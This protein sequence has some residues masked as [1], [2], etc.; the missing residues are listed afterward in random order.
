ME[1]R[2]SCKVV[3]DEGLHVTR[4][5]GL[6]GLDDSLCHVE[7]VLPAPKALSGLCPTI[8]CLNFIDAAM[9]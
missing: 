2:Q 8:A 5:K 7:N 6:G 4:Q 1:A 9:E 3:L